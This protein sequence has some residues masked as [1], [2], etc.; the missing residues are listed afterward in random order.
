M[1][2]NDLINFLRMSKGMETLVKMMLFVFV[3]TVIAIAGGDID[4]YGCI[5]SAGYVWCDDPEVQRCIR[6]WEEVCDTIIA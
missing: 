4:S 6:I 5:G 2:S 1:Y 3:P